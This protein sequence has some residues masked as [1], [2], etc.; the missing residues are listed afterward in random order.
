MT[1]SVKSKL[2]KIR[3]AGFDSEQEKVIG[4]AVEW[5]AANKRQNKPVP[6]LREVQALLKDEYGIT[7]SR[8]ALQSRVNRW[9]P[10]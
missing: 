9:S 1:S 10:K 6:P 7:I 2:R 8:S 3:P 4:D 5:V